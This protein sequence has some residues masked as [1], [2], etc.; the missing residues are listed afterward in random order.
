MHYL[1]SL[2][3]DYRNGFNYGL[4]VL[5]VLIPL[6]CTRIVFLATKRRERGASI[7][8]WGGVSY[9]LFFALFYGFIFG[10]LPGGPSRLYVHL[11][12]NISA[13]GI[14]VAI[15][16]YLALESSYTSRVLTEKL[17]E[18]QQLSTE[19]QQILLTQNE[20]LEKQ[21]TLRTAELNHSLTELKTTQ[22]QLIQKEKLASLGE[23][24]AGI[25][26]EIQNVLT[27]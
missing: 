26:H 20:V 21:V 8:F 22:T 4:T 11:A 3:C 5:I 24:T 25:A 27:P 19:K 23:L 1:V 12:Y 18:V 2:Y 16:V 9:L 10:Y 13:L 15:S 14:P 7:V 6:E 17:S